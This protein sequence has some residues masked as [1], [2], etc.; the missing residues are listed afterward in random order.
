MNFDVVLSVFIHAQK[1]R[2]E[3]NLV[4]AQSWRGCLCACTSDVCACVSVR[5]KLLTQRVTVP[6]TSVLYMWGFYM[7]ALCLRAVLISSPDTRDWARMHALVVMH[8]RT[9]CENVDRAKIKVP[10]YK[11]RYFTRGI[12]TLYR[13]IVT[14]QI[15]TTTFIFSYFH[16][17]YGLVNNIISLLSMQ[18]ALLFYSSMAHAFWSFTHVMM[19]NDLFALFMHLFYLWDFFYGDI[20]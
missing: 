8:R 1:S 3:L 2:G 17:Q 12:D 11:Y 19:S 5:G 20:W 15:I 16:Q 7:L 10:F 18:M 6:P 4:F 14:P 13:Y 9:L